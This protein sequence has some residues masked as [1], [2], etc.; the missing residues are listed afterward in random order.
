MDLGNY[1]D[2]PW[3]LMDKL[4]IFWI[5]MTLEIIHQIQKGELNS[6]RNFTQ[7]TK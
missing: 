7:D 2:Y 5:F 6:S 4:D 1:P 3:V